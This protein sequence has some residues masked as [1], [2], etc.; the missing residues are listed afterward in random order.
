M[1]RIMIV[2]KAFTSL[3]L[4]PLFLSS[5]EAS[6]PIPVKHSGP[7]SNIAWDMPQIN[8]VRGGDPER[9][10]EINKKMAC[11]SC[12]GE[13]GT[14]TADN[15]PSIAGQKATYTFKMLIDYRDK[16]RAGTATSNLMVKLAKEMTEQEMADVSAY[17]ASFSLPPATHPKVATKAEVDTI[18]PLLTKGD[19]SRL[20]PPCLSCHGK[21]AE[22]SIMDIPS[23]AGQRAE[24]F[25]KTMKEFQSGAR[26][27]D[28]YAR[29]RYIS[30]ALTD[31]EINAL[32]QYFAE[33]QE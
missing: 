29:M 16:K 11:E 7:S 32:A 23:L 6:E 26:H 31:I 17:Y 1:H 2:I 3:G 30:K 13:K 24:Y 22:G 10:K 21:N 9:G 5:L 15:W 14:A 4:L 28:I 12:H 19:G 27:N 20:L 25:R 33:M 18:L 8:F